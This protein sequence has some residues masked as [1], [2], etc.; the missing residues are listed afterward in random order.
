MFHIYTDGAT[1]PRN[2]GPSAW[3]Y[4]VLADDHETILQE[5]CGMW[6]HS[7]NQRAELKAI[8]TALY[9]PSGEAWPEMW[10]TLDIL[11]SGIP[12]LRRNTADK[13]KEEGGQ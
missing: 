13:E 1:L 7:T 5:A 12:V 10:A 2:P 9:P 4:V 3:G 6:R 11:H 8:V